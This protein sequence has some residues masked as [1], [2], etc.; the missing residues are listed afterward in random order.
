M[1]VPASSSQHSS[2]PSFDN[3]LE[4]LPLKPI[5]HIHSRHSSLTK[6]LN[7]LNQETI[8]FLQEEPPIPHATA[9]GTHPSQ[10]NLFSS[11]S[12]R[13]EQSPPEKFQ[14]SSQT[15]SNDDP[16]INKDELEANLRKTRFLDGL[17]TP[18]TENL[19]LKNRSNLDAEIEDLIDQ[20]SVHFLQIFHHFMSCLSFISDQSYFEFVVTY[21]MG[22]FLDSGSFYFTTKEYQ[23]ILDQVL[24]RLIGFLDSQQFVLDAVVSLLK[25]LILKNFPFIKFEE[26]GFQ[27]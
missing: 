18:T 22:V 27:I 13:P 7:I 9:S 1:S 15:A 10:Q 2:D 24:V 14:D 25:S 3:P 11:L 23:S 6:E 19:I 12:S 21:M 17:L 4:S 20:T 8:Q 5:L 16:D 26:V